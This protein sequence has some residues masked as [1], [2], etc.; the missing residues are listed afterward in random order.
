MARLEPRPL[1]AHLTMTPNGS[2]APDLKPARR[3]C[4]LCGQ[5]ATCGAMAIDRFGEAFCSDAH[6]DEFVQS[7]RAARI[8]AAAKVETTVEGV[9]SR[10][11]SPRGFSKGFPHPWGA[12]VGS[13]LPGHSRIRKGR[14]RSAGAA[15]RIA[16][17]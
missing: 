6:A 4:G 17:A 2:N 15:P 9:V 1:S 7:V 11:V 5:P 12:A 14:A 13:L 3:Y 16:R 10:K 8:Q